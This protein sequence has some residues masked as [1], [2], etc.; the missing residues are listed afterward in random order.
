MNQNPQVLAYL[1]GSLC[2][3]VLDSTIHPFIYYYGGKY[4]H[5]IKKLKS[6]G[7]DMTIWRV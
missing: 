7:E 2:H 4:E 5:L 1:Y 6:I 3:Y